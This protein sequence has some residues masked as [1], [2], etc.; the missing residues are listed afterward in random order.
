MALK[1]ED[2]TEEQWADIQADIDRE[3]LKASDTARKN[4]EKA[5]DAALAEKV[6]EAVNDERARLEMSEQQKLEAE[7]KKV[8][9]ASAALAKERKGLMAEKKLVGAGFPE[10]SIE[11]LLPLFVGLDDAAFGGAVDSF[12]SMNQSLV[13][14][15]VDTLKQELLHNAT[16]P[17]TP[18][19]ASVDQNTAAMEAAKA[20]NAAEAIDLLISGAPTV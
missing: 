14:T 9:D 10:D 18:P 1:K 7:R 3:R 5:A 16:P 13:K 8:E 6:T 19:G 20:G 15:Q 17:N 4:A 12:I 11:T 2:F